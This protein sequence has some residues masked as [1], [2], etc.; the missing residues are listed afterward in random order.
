MTIEGISFECRK[1]IYF[2]L[3]TLH[4]QLKRLAARFHAIRGKQKPIV[5]HSFVFPHFASPTCGNGCL[6]ND[7]DDTEDDDTED[8]ATEDDAWSKMNLQLYQQNSRLSRSVR[9]ANGSKNMLKLNMQ[10]R[11]SIPNGNTKNQP[12]SSTF[13]RGRRTR[14]IMQVHSYCFAH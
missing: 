1:L 5:T 8:D 3:T 4:D 6:S 7:H 2:A 12:S 11:R 14:F 9:C 13:R 10:R